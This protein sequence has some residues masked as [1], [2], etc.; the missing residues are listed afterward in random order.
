[1]ADDSKPQPKRKN[2]PGRPFVKGQSGNPAG[3]PKA[4]LEVRRQLAELLPKA[5][6]T[7]AELL[8][9]EDGKVRVMAVKEVYDRT[10]GK[11]TQPITGEN[12]EPLKIDLVPLL[13]RL[14]K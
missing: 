7:L 1:V 2:G 13:E 3:V 5:T 12:G 11:P 4:F 6:Q 9:H 14:A 8:D 10:M